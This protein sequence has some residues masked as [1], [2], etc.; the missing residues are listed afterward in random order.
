MNNIRYFLGIF[1]IMAFL[2][3]GCASI[4]LVGETLVQPV[5]PIAT[6]EEINELNAKIMKYGGYAYTQLTEEEQDVYEEI[7]LCIESRMEDMDSM[8][9]DYDMFSN[10]F[11][12]VLIDHPEFF[13][14]DGFD[15]VQE[16]L[17][18]H[19][20]GFSF[21]PNYT[22]TDQE[23]ETYEKANQAYVK[24][25]KQQIKNGASDYDIVKSVYEYIIL[26]TEY[27][28]DAI[29]DQTI[30]SVT[31]YGSS[32]CQGYAETMQYVLN[33]LGVFSTLVF[34]VLPVN[35]RHTWNLVC[36]DGAYYHVDCTSGDPFYVEPAQEAET[37]RTEVVSYDYLGLT[38]E[39]IGITHVIDH[40]V[41]LPECTATKNHYYHKEG[42]YFTEYDLDKL[43]DIF[44]E[45]QNK[46]AEFV[47]FQ[48]ASR[49]VYDEMMV[50][51]L[52]E[53][54]IFTLIREP[55]TGIVF[56]NDDERLIFT[57][58]LK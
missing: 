19:I 1:V 11:N 42:L 38:T 34:G 12:C 18:D 46:D 30:C 48:C 7:F 5:E 26:N 32:V 44:D 28:E 16:K 27:N 58:Y 55:G 15:G 2:L 31:S 6:P 4:D 47:A 17:G 13:Y 9:S 22:M 24:K 49:D 3:Q 54:V 33:E 50:Q 37:G 51:L 43:Q 23:I 21:T 20:V 41:P 8:T 14:V 35:E 57:F 40:L 25:C 52:D 10:V 36:M 45:G 56:A 39:Q 29:L 53:Q